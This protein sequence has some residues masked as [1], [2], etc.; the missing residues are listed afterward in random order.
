MNI[1]HGKREWSLDDIEGVRE[2]IQDVQETTGWS[3]AEISRR[4][5]VAEATLSQFMKGNYKGTYGN[6]A[7]D[8]SKWLDQHHRENEFKRGAPVEPTFVQTLTAQKV[9][10]A[11]QH[12]QVLNDISVVVGPPGCGKTASTDQYAARNQRVMKLTASPAISSPNAVLAS[13]IER[14]H[15]NAS[16][17]STR[18]LVHRSN[19]VRGML[20]KGWL[21]VIDEAQHLSIS[22]L[23]ELRA[24]QDEVQCGLVLIGNPTVLSRIQGA[25]RDASYAQIFGRVGWRVVLKKED[26]AADVAM[27]LNTM[28]V[29]AAEVLKVATDIGKREDL[30]VV[31]KTTRSAMMLANGSNE[32]LEPKHMRAAYKQLSG[33]AA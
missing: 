10:A 2:A 3:R 30:R 26:L 9:M 23:E 12:A 20:K 17:V 25:S 6:V 28:G 33:E 1:E 7:A 11:L 19:V 8:L 16:L 15:A 18:S 13:L 32:N 14:H 31:V 5:Q 24:I 22:A 4:S 21:L 27:V 29:T